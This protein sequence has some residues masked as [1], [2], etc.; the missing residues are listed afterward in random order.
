M[1]VRRY[2]AVSELSVRAPNRQ[3]AGI[4]LLVV[5]ELLSAVALRVNNLMRTVCK[6]T[7]Y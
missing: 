6:T 3:N 2:R 1:M 5:E 4:A 7:G